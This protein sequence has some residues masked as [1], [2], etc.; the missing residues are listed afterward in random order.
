MS[1]IGVVTVA[2]I[3]ALAILIWLFIRARTSDQI[4]EFL[5]KR[6]ANSKIATRAEFVEGLERMPVAL[7]LSDAGLSYENHD[8]QASLDLNRLEEV[9]YDDEL[10]TGKEIEDA[11]VLRIRSH[12]QTFEFILDKGSADRWV[13]ALPARRL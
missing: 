7:A 2:G 8:L 11:K 10:A 3:V 12:G 9:E 5:T 6:R 1:W 13:A 4:E